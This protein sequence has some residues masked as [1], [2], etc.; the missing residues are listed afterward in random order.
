VKYAVRISCRTK[1]A[2]CDKAVEFNYFAVPNLFAELLPH[3]I[4]EL[5]QHMGSTAY[6]TG[7]KCT[8]ADATKKQ[9]LMIGN[10]I[11]CLSRVPDFVCHQ[12]SIVF[13]REV[14]L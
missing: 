1:V 6:E 10:Q 2:L 7:L 5:F 13:T 11:L 4:L 8:G 3:L 12:E 14:K 9:S